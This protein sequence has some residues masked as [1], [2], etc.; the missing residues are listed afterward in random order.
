MSDHCGEL[1]PEPAGE[2]EQPLSFRLWDG[3]GGS[4]LPENFQT[5]VTAVPVVQGRFHLRPF[6][7]EVVER[8]IPHQLIR[9]GQRGS[10]LPFDAHRRGADPERVIRLQMCAGSSDRIPA[11]S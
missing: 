4:I 7:A 1:Q 11:G 3:G 9:A 5:L 10:D 2:A 8:K 6:N